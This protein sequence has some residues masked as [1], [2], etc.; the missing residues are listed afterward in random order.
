MLPISI[1]YEYY[2]MCMFVCVFCMMNEYSY[3]LVSLVKMTEHLWN[4]HSPLN[5]ISSVPGYVLPLYTVRRF[6]SVGLEAN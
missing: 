5:P 2:C 1:Q 6:R 3:N 4:V